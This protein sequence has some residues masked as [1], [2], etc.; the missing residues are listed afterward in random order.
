MRALGYGKLFIVFLL[1]SAGLMDAVAVVQGQKA[2]SAVEYLSTYGWA[3]LVLALVLAALVGLGIFSPQSFVNTSCTFPAEI[4]CLSS[5]FYS[6]N[7]VLAINIQQATTG[8]IEVTAIGCNNQSTYTNMQVQS[9]NG[10]FIGIGGNY[11]FSVQCYG[12]ASVIPTVSPGQIYKG[13][14]LVNYTDIQSNFPHS[15]IGQLITKAS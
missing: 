14:V 8:P 2:Q 6:S 1:S 5:I 10:I 9:G 15:A 13:Q 11:T 7:S 12:A 4:S 3:I